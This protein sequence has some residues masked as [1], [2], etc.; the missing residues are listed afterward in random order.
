VNNYKTVKA[1]ARPIN[2]DHLRRAAKVDDKL[3]GPY[4]DELLITMH[5]SLDGWRYGKVGAEPLQTALDAFV[6]LMTE[7]ENRGLA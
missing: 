1:A 5:Q 4:M 7:A 2:P 3:I 6:A